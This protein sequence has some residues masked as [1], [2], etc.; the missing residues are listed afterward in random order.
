[1]L[2]PEESAV[3]EKSNESAAL[4]DTEVKDAYDDLGVS[5]GWFHMICTRTASI[6]TRPPKYRC[7][8]GRNRGA[9]KGSGHSVDMTVRTEF[10]LRTGCIVDGS[11]SSVRASLRVVMVWDG[12]MCP[13]E[14]GDPATFDGSGVSQAGSSSNRAPRTSECMSVQ[15]IG[16]T[17]SEVPACSY[18][19]S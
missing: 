13:L 17:K 14:G 8:S 18:I 12:R 19:K 11:S 2:W 16:R 4:V 10:E 9:L 7:I 3:A 6:Y 1:M 5:G 15:Q